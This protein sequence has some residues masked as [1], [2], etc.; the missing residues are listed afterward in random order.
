MKYFLGFVCAVWGL[1]AF[2]FGGTVPAGFKTETIAQGINAGTALTIVPDGTVYFAEQTGHI[3]MVRD[4]LLLERPLLDISARVDTFWEHGLVGMEFDPEYPSKPYLYVLYVMK[5]PYAHHVV[6]RFTVEND[7]ANLASERVLF[8]GDDQASLGGSQPSAHQGGPMRFGPDGKLYIGLGEQTEDSAAQSMETLQG[9]ILRLNPDGS[10]PKDNPFYGT[11]KGKFR[12]IYALGI[13]NPFGLAFQPGTGRLFEADIGKSSFDE[14]NEI[15]AGRNY[16]WPLAEGMSDNERFTNPTHAYPPAIGRCICGS[17]FYPSSGDFPDPWKGKLF[18]VDWASN[19]IKAID[20]D[21]PKEALDFGSDFD[22]PVA[23]E[24]SPD[25]SIWVLNRNT[26][27]RDQK[28]FENNSGS[29]TRIRYVGGDYNESESMDYPLT[30]LE[31]GVWEGASPFQ[32]VR[33]FERFEMNLPIW[34]PGIRVENWLRIP[35]NGRISSLPNGDWIF[36][37]GAE[38]IQHFESASGDPH[39]T[40]LY[41]SNGDGTFRT[42]AYRWNGEFGDAGF[43]ASTQYLPIKSDPFN[44]WLSPG[45]MAKLDPKTAIFGFQ[46][47]FNARQLNWGSQLAEWNDRSWFEDALSNRTLSGQP[48]LH[49]LDDESIPVV[50]R[51]RSYLDVNCA[52]CHKPG[53]ASR[54]YFDARLL[55]AFEEQNLLTGELMAGDLGVSGAKLVTPGD[56]EK[57]VLYLRLA[58]KDGFRMPPGSTSIEDSPVLLLMDKWIREMDSADSGGGGLRIKD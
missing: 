41:Q 37:A 4:G 20:V 46:P 52:S 51:V 21:N 27:W 23:I 18:F 47:Q 5:L 19:W 15:K 34:R 13:R 48:K 12:S 40:H 50:D 30:L 57:S 16:G 2:V 55:T 42:S 35:E 58:R 54:G 43:V 28:K 36:P 32:P 25:G 38:I 1:N 49:A 3:R 31:T 56:P 29:L 14:I 6:S 26:R 44:M 17:M 22:S 24:A 33:G 8:E 11:A 10:I 53:G 9:K 45:P 39:E 7:V